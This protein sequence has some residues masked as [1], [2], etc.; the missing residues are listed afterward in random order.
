MPPGS[1]VWHVQNSFK[2][3]FNRDLLPRLEKICDELGFGQGV[4]LR[5]DKL[6]INTGSIST[7]EL[8][9]VWVAEVEKAFREELISQKRARFS[10]EQIDS[11]N[12]TEQSGLNTF[13]YFLE[14]GVLPWWISDEF[15]L[16]LEQ[17]FQKLLTDQPRE[18]VSRIQSVKNKPALVNRLL[19]QFKPKELRKLLKHFEQPKT[20]ADLNL[21]KSILTKGKQRLS[22]AL[23]ASF[24]FTEMATTINPTLAGQDHQ[25]LFELLFSQLREHSMDSGNIAL[26][27]IHKQLTDSKKALKTSKSLEDSEVISAAIH[28]ASSILNSIASEAGITAEQSLSKG[29]RKSDQKGR[30]NDTGSSTTINQKQQEHKLVEKGEPATGQVRAGESLTEDG[31]EE[32]GIERKGSNTTDQTNAVQQPA[33][34]SEDSGAISG[35][36]ELLSDEDK[37]AWEHIE[38]IKKQ[39]LDKLA[40]GKENENSIGQSGKA[41]A[42][43]KDITEESDSLTSADISDTSGNSKDADSPL[44]STGPENSK[45][46]DN[47]ETNDPTPPEAKTPVT[48]E[49]LYAGNPLGSEE[50]RYQDNQETGD[51]DKNE[52]RASDAKPQIPS[53]SIKP[54]TTRPLRKPDQNSLKYWQEALESIDECYVQNAGLILLWPFLGQFLTA[55]GLVVD[56]EFRSENDQKK[57]TLVLQHLINPEPELDEYRLPLNKLM[58]GLPI[59][60]PVGKSINLS[61]GEADQCKNLLEATIHNW[62]ALRGTSVEGFQSSFLL[63]KGVLKRHDSHWLLQVEKMPFDMLMDQL[64]WPISIVRLSWMNKPIYVEW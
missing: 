34:L 16:T 19:Y 15:E 64:P 35:E 38:R 59:S 26:A 24:F 12:D 61:G 8:T 13:M 10:E 9:N 36:Q 54:D 14:R 37:R 50:E 43:Q 28:V 48:E 57:A 46:S 1:D 3:V 32:N 2:E 27:E 62:S 49:I 41:K 60:E 63:R 29:Q 39:Q 55:M 53:Q 45:L 33:P 22:E 52:H 31:L 6:T 44:E 25:K 18:L 40:Q 23:E 4:G 58:C 7:A 17:L 51:V 56:G 47:A 42:P 21:I 20:Q 11:L 5:L 30:E